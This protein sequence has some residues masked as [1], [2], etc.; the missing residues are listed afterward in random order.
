MTRDSL[1]TLRLDGL[2]EAD[3]ERDLSFGPSALDPL[4][5]GA[6]FARAED[7]ADAAAPLVSVESLQSSERR[8]AGL[9]VLEPGTLVD[10]YRI[11]RLLGAGG[12][13]AVYLAVHSILNSRFALK[14]LRR[15][16]VKTQRSLVAQLYRE[17]R[18]AARIDHHNVVRVF[19]VV[20][21]AD[22]AYLVLEYV[23]GGSLSDALHAGGPL[24]VRRAVEVARGVAAGLAAGLAA[25]VIHRDIKPANILLSKTGAKV[26]DFGLAVLRD[27]SEGKEHS[28]GTPGYVSPEQAARGAID[29]RADI[30]SLGVTLHQAITGIAPRKPS[31]RSGTAVPEPLPP[32]SND[33]PGMNDDLV[34]LI[35]SMANLDREKRP[36][37]YEELDSRLDAVLGRMS[38]ET[39]T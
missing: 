1:F 31:M 34:E 17:A 26:T 4:L 25:G 15:K 39:E 35:S 14:V 38:M 36:R 24:P 19:D 33:I 6:C 12:F 7:S 37:T 13:G 32:I 28:G 22:L 9:D 29:H 16:I 18:I 27:L 23:D 21:H 3:A 5:P 10:R 8:L 20:E 2:Y 11:E 30:F